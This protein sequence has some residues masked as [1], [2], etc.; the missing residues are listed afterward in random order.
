MKAMKLQ[1]SVRR[2][3]EA[4]PLDDVVIDAAEYPKL[5]ERVY[6]AAEFKRPRN[7]I[8]MLKE[9]PPEEMEALILATLPIDDD[10]LRH[11]AQ[12]R[13]QSIKSRL[14]EQEQ[15]EAER[16]FL[17]APKVEAAGEQEGA[18]ARRAQFSLR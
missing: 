6:R 10:A 5:L 7:A 4:P 11:L 12:D 17:I 3:D 2:G 9:L 8:G 16:I 13:A 1:E 18:A 14:L 15:V